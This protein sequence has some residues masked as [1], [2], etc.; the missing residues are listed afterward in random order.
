LGPG[1][2][3][4]VYEEC[5]CKELATADLEFRRQVAVPVT[6][7]GTHLE[8]GYRADLVVEDEVLVEIKAVERLMPVHEAQVLSYLRL[9]GF[10]KGLLI[11]FHSKLLK[12]GIKRFVV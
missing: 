6:Y 1:L 5:L 8:T 3:E 10:P 2:L 11:N 9:G 7:K 12:D 4:A